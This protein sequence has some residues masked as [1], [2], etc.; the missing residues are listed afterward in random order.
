MRQL[1]E[2]KVYTV[3]YNA[4]DNRLYFYKKTY[5]NNIRYIGNRHITDIIDI[6]EQN[7]EKEG[8]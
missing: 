6:V 1:Y 4:I 5:D 8:I 7:N 3:E 2:N